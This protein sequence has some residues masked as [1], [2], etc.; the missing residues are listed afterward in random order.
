MGKR[1]TLLVGVNVPELSAENLARDFLAEIP[2]RIDALP[3]A[4]QRGIADEE[5][6]ILSVLFEYSMDIVLF[7]IKHTI[8]LLYKVFYKRFLYFLRVIWL[9]TRYCY[10]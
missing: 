6:L 7:F 3:T 10:I 9:N 2:L 8:I 4:K 1:I 5:K